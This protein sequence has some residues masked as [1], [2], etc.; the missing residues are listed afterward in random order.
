MQ[1]EKRR[2]I[3][4]EEQRRILAAELNPE[5]HRFYRLLWEIGSAQTD[6]ANLAAE[7]IEWNRRV[8]GCG[9]GK[10]LERYLA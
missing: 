10:G 5:W 7:N 1:C 6:A 8:L 9:S 4:E 3:T 2:G